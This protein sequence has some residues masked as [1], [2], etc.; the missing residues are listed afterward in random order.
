MG[1][2]TCVTAPSYK[3]LRPGAVSTALRFAIHAAP[4]D[5]LRRTVGGWVSRDEE[6]RSARPQCRQ[7]RDEEHR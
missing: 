5:V 7:Q 4:D 1:F 2:L 3:N 6:H